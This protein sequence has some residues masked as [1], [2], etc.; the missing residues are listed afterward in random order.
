MKKRH[1]AE[2]QGQGR[3]DESVGSR[4]GLHN[5]YLG[6]R[7]YRCQVLR[8]DMDKNLGF[9]QPCVC[10][11]HINPKG[12]KCRKYNC[13]DHLVVAVLF[14]ADQR[15]HCALCDAPFYGGGQ[16]QLELRLL[17]TAL[18]AASVGVLIAIPA[19]A[20][21]SAGLGFA[22]THCAMCHA[23]RNA[24]NSPHQAA[25]PFR[26]LGSSIDLDRLQADLE[27]GTVLPSHPDMPSF[28]MDPNTA[29]EIVNY[30]R[31]IQE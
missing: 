19:A 9:A 8:T 6:P 23:V 15:A 5:P 22:E 26:L 16:L 29:K 2:K 10:I 20:Q 13:C 24:D 12:G 11:R 18:K 28:K 3:A 1:K 25:P 30:I 21:P 27:N 31:S 4:T 7:A 17:T 14:D